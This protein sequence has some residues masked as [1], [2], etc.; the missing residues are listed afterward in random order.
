MKKCIAV[1][2]VLLLFLGLSACGCTESIE[3]PTMPQQMAAPGLPAEDPN[4]K[5]SEESTD[6]QDP[7]GETYP[8]ETEFREEDYFV[9][10]HTEPKVGKFTN[11]L[12]GNMFG[13]CVRTVSEYKNGEI[14]DTYFY[15]NGVNSHSYTWYPDGSYV[16]YHH[17]NDGRID[18][19]ER[20]TYLGTVIYQKSIAPDGSW[21]EY[22]SDENGIPVF[23]AS[24]EADGTYWEAYYFESGNCSNEISYNP[25][26][27]E[28]WETEYYENCDSKK[29]VFSNSQT[30]EYTQFEY[31]ENGSMKNCKSQSPENTQEERFDEEGF[32]TYFYMK[33]ADS[34]IEL[35]SDESGMLISYMDSGTVYESEDIPDWVA[36]SYNFRG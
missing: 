28:R 7:T 35:I 36:G 21:Y 13:T 23:S 27:G 22:R 32:H 4:N 31:F 24:M 9:Y 20:K 18:L 3:L 6:A 25:S 16:E 19:A 11:Y 12:E 29:T 5:A 2:T 33:N 8:W 26:T 17:L 14:S 10:V 15:P 1:L 34:E 30:G